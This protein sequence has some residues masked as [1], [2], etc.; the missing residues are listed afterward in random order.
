MRVMCV[1]TKNCV[2]LYRHQRVDR[3]EEMAIS[4]WRSF[5][6]MRVDSLLR[7][8]RLSCQWISI[9]TCEASPAHIHRTS[10]NQLVLT[11]KTDTSIASR[12]FHASWR[13]VRT[14][15]PHEM[16]CF[17]QTL[18]KN[19]GWI[20]SPGFDVD[21]ALDGVMIA[22]PVEMDCWITLIA[23]GKLSHY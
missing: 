6:P 7:N 4:S 12:G 19:H 5:F 1:V 10:S 9:H 22:Q 13:A 2:A 17:N 20:Q 15:P 21:P 18:V 11:F 23:P 3:Y 14:K 16:F 8:K